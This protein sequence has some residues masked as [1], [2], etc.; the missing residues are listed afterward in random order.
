MTYPRLWRVWTPF[1]AATSLT[2]PLKPLCRYCKVP[3]RLLVKARLS[4]VLAADYIWWFDRRRWQ[5]RIQ[6]QLFGATCNGQINRDFGAT[7]SPRVQA[8]TAELFP[9]AAQVPARIHADFV[10]SSLLIETHRTY[11]VTLLRANVGARCAETDRHLKVAGFLPYRKTV[12]A[13][14][15]L[16]FQNLYSCRVLS[17]MYDINAY[18]FRINSEHKHKCDL[19]IYLHEGREE[20][21]H[22]DQGVCV[23]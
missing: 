1:S 13:W 11:P 7:G 2:K 17:V 3:P 19:N 20:K 22:A 4:G 6:H 15:R 21:Q 23:S 16:P 10:W 18:H 14:K 5:E 9:Q 8:Q 12:W